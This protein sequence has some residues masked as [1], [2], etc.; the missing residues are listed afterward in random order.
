MIS[1]KRR[2]CSDGQAKSL[3]RLISVKIAIN[4]EFDYFSRKLPKSNKT[5]ILIPLPPSQDMPFC[6][7]HIQ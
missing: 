7:Y 3:A 6:T 1:K 5:L 4:I 2:P